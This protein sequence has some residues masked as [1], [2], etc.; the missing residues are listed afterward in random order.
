MRRHQFTLIAP[1]LRG[2]VDSD[3]PSGPFG[4]QEPPP[5]CWPCLMR[6]A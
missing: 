4:A 5:T 1:D 3:K 2:F 6:S